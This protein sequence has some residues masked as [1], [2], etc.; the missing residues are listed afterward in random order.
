MTFRL[1]RVQDSGH[2]IGFPLSGRNFVGP[3]GAQ[4]DF[5]GAHGGNPH[6][7]SVILGF[8][9]ARALFFVNGDLSLCRN[10]IL[11]ALLDTLTTAMAEAEKKARLSGEQVPPT[12]NTASASVL[13]TTEKPQPPP[14]SSLHPAYYIVA[15][16]GFSG[17]V[18][19]FN[20][21]VLDTLKFSM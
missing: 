14:K 18:I 3:W 20:K 16:I 7:I 19:L 13:P 15:W 2:S 12:L 1:A 10:R 21:W 6:L 9:I 4:G 17:G 8:G 11:R 5:A